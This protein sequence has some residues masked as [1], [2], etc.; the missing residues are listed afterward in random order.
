LNIGT[1]LG[2]G[3]IAPRGLPLALM[4]QDS[5]FLHYLF[6]KKYREKPYVKVAYNPMK[7]SESVLLTGI[8]FFHFY[9]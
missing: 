9:M 8:Q 6:K 4:K 1:K 5:D 7:P 3:N 2:A